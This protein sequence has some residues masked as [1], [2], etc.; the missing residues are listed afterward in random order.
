VIINRDA[1]FDVMFVR[2]FLRLADCPLLGRIVR[3]Q[4]NLLIVQSLLQTILV[5]VAVCGCSIYKVSHQVLDWNICWKITIV[6][7]PLSKRTK[8]SSDLF[9]LSH[10]LRCCEPAW[11]AFVKRRRFFFVLNVPDF[12]EV[13]VAMNRHQ[14]FRPILRPMARTDLCPCLLAFNSF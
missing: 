12:C 10:C 4:T 6:L 8:G 11:C 13:T 1:T 14:K 7:D 5:S 3:V 2:L 9:C